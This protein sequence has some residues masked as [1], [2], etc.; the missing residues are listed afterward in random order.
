[1]T[2]QARNRRRAEG[3]RM[4]EQFRDNEARNRFELDIEGTIAFITYRKSAGAITLVRTFHKTEDSYRKFCKVCGGH[5]M[6]DHPR[7]RL[8]DVYANLL[9]GFPHE[10]T[11][12][13]NYG[14]RMFSV[15]DGLP[16]FRD[17]PAEL[18]GSGETLPD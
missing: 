9:Q 4:T 2:E 15:R 18:G 12:H 3:V 14:S 10:P 5:L 7:M 6:T 16:K 13:A 17:L 11:L 1:L 8:V